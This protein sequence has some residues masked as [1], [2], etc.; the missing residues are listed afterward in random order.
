MFFFFFYIMPRKSIYTPQTFG[1]FIT[2]NVIILQWLSL[3]QKQFFA[4][5]D[6][7]RVHMK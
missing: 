6:Q 2:R 1:Y 7:E 5:V 4:D 3:N